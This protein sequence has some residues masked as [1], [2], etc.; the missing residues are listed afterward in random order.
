MKNN[1]L[2]TILSYLGFS[3]IACFV[4]SKHFKLDF[5]IISGVLISVPKAV[6]WLDILVNKKTQSILDL[7]A[8]YNAKDL[9]QDAL[10]RQVSNTSTKTEIVVSQ[11]SKYQ[12]IYGK[13][14][15]YAD[16][17]HDCND[18]IKKLKKFETDFEKW[19]K[20]AHGRNWRE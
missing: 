10:L 12:E 11:L 6:D 1:N 3:V 2:T 4:L 19:F 9:Q 20:D 18:E 17:M 7:E 16:S 5:T 13:L 15:D 14:Q 8:K